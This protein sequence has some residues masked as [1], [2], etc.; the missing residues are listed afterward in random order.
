MIRRALVLTLMTTA[1]LGGDVAGA[2][3]VGLP[4]RVVDWTPSSIATRSF[5]STDYTDADAGPR[6]ANTLW[7]TVGSTGNAAELWLT[8]AKSG[9]ILDL[10]GRYV[11]Y[12]DDQGRT[13]KSVRTQEEL[14]NGEGSILQAPNGDVVGITWDPYAGDRIIT[15]KYNAA[16]KSWYYMAQP[17]HTPFWDRPSIQV[18]PGKYTDPAGR[19]STYMTFVNGLPHDPWQYSYDGLNYTGVSSPSRDRGEAL[20]SWLD[21]KP[22][23]MW[24]YM[25]PNNDL[26]QGLIPKFTPV[27]AGRAW[28]Q[29]LFFTG[30]DIRWHPWTLPGGKAIDGS[31]QVDSRGWLHNVVPAG[32]SKFTYRIS[33]DG[34]RTWNA[35]TASGGSAG[36]F[37]AN[38]AAGVAAVYAITG[39]QDLVYKIDISTARPKLIR[40]YTV[41]LGDDSRSG[42]VGFYGATGGHRFDFSSIG[43]FPDGRVAVSFMDSQTTMPFPTLGNDASC[44][45][46][47]LPPDPVGKSPCVV[48]A[49]QLAIEQDT[50]V[51]D[52]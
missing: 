22:D 21:V 11:N 40:R 4:A 12:S 6:K 15:Y 20:N 7:R 48:V 16:D 42:G 27:G 1:A 33:T 23:P 52:G 13:W 17:I 49:P 34:G 5:P 41:G 44:A 25:Q 30:D 45:V 10:G 19:P 8:V 3:E 50:T 35:L 2:Q 37:R 24:D 43:V 38:A 18:V 47:D 32:N 26:G 28:Y 29:N 51:A 36:D 14:V 39:Q 31:L 9:R 46:K